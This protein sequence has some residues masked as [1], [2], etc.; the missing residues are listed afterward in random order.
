LIGSIENINQINRMS[1]SDIFSFS[2]MT[3][4]TLNQQERISTQPSEFAFDQAEKLP[5]TIGNTGQHRDSAEVVCTNSASLS[6][7]S[8]TFTPK[9]LKHNQDVYLRKQPNTSRNP[10]VKN[11]MG[12]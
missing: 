12:D 1:G 10:T 6:A 11:I 3:F 9:I 5:I 8:K 7:S 4:K 2:P